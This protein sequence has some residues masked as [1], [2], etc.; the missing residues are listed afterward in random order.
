MGR[1]KL[2]ALDYPWQKARKT[3]QGQSLESIQI[4]KNVLQKYMKQ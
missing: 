4:N 2:V 1:F 3:T